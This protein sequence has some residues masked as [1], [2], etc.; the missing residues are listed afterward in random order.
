MIAWTSTVRALMNERGVL[1]ELLVLLVSYAFVYA[2]AWND[3]LLGFAPSPLSHA[4]EDLMA[5]ILATEIALRLRFTRDKNAGFWTLCSLDAVSLLTVLPLVDWIG[6]ARIGRALYAAARLTRL[7]DRLA[8]E[9]NNGLYVVAI[10]PFAVPPIAAA[11]FALDQHARG[12]PIHN[13]LDALR[14]CFGFALSLGQVRPATAAAMVLCGVLFV[15][16]LLALNVV[17]N[18]LSARYEHS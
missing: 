1:H 16:G 9:R 13:Y 11:V 2:G 18:T 8:C 3:G 7:L 10:F 6:L 12:T 5:L 4:A 14:V 17:A 15:L